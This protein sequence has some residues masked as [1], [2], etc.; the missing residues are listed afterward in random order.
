MSAPFLDTNVLLYALGDDE[1][2]S[3]ARELIESGGI[4]ALQSLNEF[5][6]V[7][8][9]KLR[10]EWPAV[11]QALSSLL[12]LCRLHETISLSTHFL[13]LSLA[14][15]YNLNIHDAMLLAIAHEANCETFISE[16]LHDGLVIHGTLTV[17]NPFA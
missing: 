16:D 15:R 13:A 12:H 4:I 2:S 9:R 6:N 17:R 8:R 10:F 7:A 11:R 5:V 1:K 14:E 3:I